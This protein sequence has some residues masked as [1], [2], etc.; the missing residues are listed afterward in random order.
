MA[1]RANPLPSKIP[2]VRAA[3]TPAEGAGGD[4]HELDETFFSPK[5]TATVR[6][7]DSLSN[8]NIIGTSSTRHWLL[9]RIHGPRATGQACRFAAEI[10]RVEAPH[11]ARPLP[12]GVPAL[13][14]HL[15]GGGLALGAVHEM[16]EGGPAG[17]FAGRRPCSSPA[18]RR[19]SKGPSSGA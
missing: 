5:F 10:A 9:A 2:P 18:S 11:K 4:A 7:F 15:P 3:P 1:S 12:F 17:E 13:D 8:E 19:A 6:A 14:R 16:A